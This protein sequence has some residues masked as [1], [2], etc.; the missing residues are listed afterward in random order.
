MKFVTGILVAAAFITLAACSPKQSATTNDTK[1]AA[2]TATTSTTPAEP[3][4]QKQEDTVTPIKKG[5][6]VT[7]QDFADI[8]V[9][10]NKIS[11]KI[12]P[13]K[14]GD[15][16]TL[17]ESKETDSTFFALIIKAKNLGA[18]GIKADKIAEVNL[19]FDNKYDYDTFSTIEER[20]G[21]DFTYTNITSVDP[22]KTGTLYYLSEI[23]NEV[24]KS[25][26]PLKA[27]IKIQDKVYEYT[28]R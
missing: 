25:E 20:G 2:T 4:E 16:H 19:K 9:T 27:E 26:K 8:T 1:Q 3:V 15:F 14:P 17:Y 7:I 10:G 18:E 21:E 23:P 6:T 11:K 28:I 22:L 5:E 13:S 12:E 24:A